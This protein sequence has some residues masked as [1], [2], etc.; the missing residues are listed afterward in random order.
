MQSLMISSLSLPR[1]LSVFSCILRITSSWFREPPFTPMRTGLP[2]S[3]ATLQMVAN[4][5]SRRWP[6]PTLPGL[7][8]YLSSAAAQSGYF[9]SSTWPL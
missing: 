3:T 7:M 4:C 5:S 8:R 1:F 9:V 6:A 2:W